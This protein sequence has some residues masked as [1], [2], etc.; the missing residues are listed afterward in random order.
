MLTRSSRVAAGMG[1]VVVVVERHR[2][3]L[4]WGTVGEI[5]HTGR[6]FGGAD[7]APVSELAL[8]RDHNTINFS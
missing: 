5:C 8:E 2:L 4:S 1:S 7:R 3:A 6:M